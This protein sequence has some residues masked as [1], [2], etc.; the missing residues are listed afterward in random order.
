MTLG[1]CLKNHYM[2]VNGIKCYWGIFYS[3]ICPCCTLLLCVHGAS[4]S[5]GIV[6]F[7][8]GKFICGLF[9]LQLAL[10]F[11]GV[12]SSHVCFTKKQVRIKDEHKIRH[13]LKSSYEIQ[14][15][16]KFEIEFENN[17]Y[18]KTSHV[19]RIVAIQGELVKSVDT[20]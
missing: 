5:A 6:V 20:L 8:C 17:L 7:D 13:K 16:S 3:S 9:W 11:I 2:L 14:G 4:S 19:L 15:K 18:F 12:H 1:I 10:C